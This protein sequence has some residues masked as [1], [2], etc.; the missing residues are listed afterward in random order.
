MA[1]Y[2][3]RGRN[4]DGAS[5]SGTL[6][7]SSQDAV[8]TRLSAQG[9]IPVSVE[10]EE[11][12]KPGFDINEWWERR[13]KVAT[14]DLIMFSRQMYTVTRTGIPL[15]QS[16]REIAGTMNNLNLRDCL[17]SV[18]DRL[19]TGMTFSQAMEP[20]QQVFGAMFQSIVKVGE[21]SGNL[22]QAFLEL[23]GYLQRDLD[24]MR[25][26]KSA[27]RYPMF[28]IV[29]FAIAIT[30]VNIWVIPAFA[31]MFS[32]FGAQLPWQTRTLMGISNFFVNYWLLLLMGVVGLGVW[33]KR[34]VATEQ[35]AL[36]YSYF[37]LNAPLI[38]DIINRATLSRY[39]RSLAIMLGAGVAINRA[40]EL[41]AEVVD[42]HYMAKKIREI[43][44]GIERGADMYATHT[45]S[46][47]F[48]PLVLQM[49]A[50]GERS[51]QVGELLGE[52]AEFYEREVEY[53]LAALSSKI[54]PLLIVMMAGFALILALGIF[55]P[56]WDMYSI[57]N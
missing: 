16:V 7:G 3:Y 25:Q 38:G 1:V 12:A 22:D 35:G 36:R 14:E 27:L 8:V 19:E 23:S 30:V 2:K 28:V 46:G 43:R 24:T 9:I 17:F 5:I 32:K 44:L 45:A 11:D 53:D 18:A 50:V 13:K 52:V 41:T 37:R 55:L 51:G 31:G 26:I 54:E 39:A 10:L 20:H 29:A 21:D 6:D 47:M 34:F 49:I 56:M 48:T 4:A 40:I 15:I 33:F 42:N 57:Q